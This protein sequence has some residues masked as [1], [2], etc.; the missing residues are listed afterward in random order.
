MQAS[1]DY[2]TSRGAVVIVAAGNDNS[3]A[4]NTQPASCRGVI[5]VANT[6]KDGARSQSS[7]YGP[8]VDVSAPGT[9]I[10]STYNDGTYSLGNASYFSMTGTSMSAPMVGGVVALVQSAAPKVLSSAEIRTLITQHTQPFRRQPDQ[11]IGPGIL[12]AAAT[13]KAAKSGEVPAAADFTCSQ[14]TAGMMLTCTDLSSARGIASIK[15]WAWNFGVANQAN[16]VRTQ[17]TNP[18]NDYEFPGTYAVT[19]TTTD[20]NGAVSR[21]SRPFTVIAPESADW[22]FEVNNQ[23]SATANVKRFFRLTVPV[24]STYL[25]VALAN[26]SSLESG[27]FYLKAGSA[28]TINPACTRPFSSSTGGSA[29]CAVT[30][31]TAGDWYMTVSP[32]TDL[33]D[34]MLYATLYP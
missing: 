27:T 18:T 13:V 4:S 15:S 11:Y 2:A 30:N 34:D 8:I 10:L 25:R 22:P 32:N 29:G 26:R 12:D 24:G 28:S 33:N 21:V 31:P 20:S 17:T 5:T 1:V 9:D 19:L 6:Q 7:N 16:I 14:S 23:I 3:D